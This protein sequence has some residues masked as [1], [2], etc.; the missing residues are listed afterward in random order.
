V[1]SARRV[2][3][4]LSRHRKSRQRFA[5]A[6][7]RASARVGGMCWAQTWAPFS[8]AKRSSRFAMS[9]SGLR[10]ALSD[11]S[12][13][14][15]D[16]SGG[17]RPPT[18]VMELALQPPEPHREPLRRS[19]SVARSQSTVRAPVRR[20]FSDCS[21]VLPL[22][23]IRA[24]ADCRGGPISHSQ[25]HGRWT[26]LWGTKLGPLCGAV[27]DATGRR[28]FSVHEP[29][30]HRCSGRRPHESVS[31]WREARSASVVGCRRVSRLRIDSAAGR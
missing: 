6:A 22:G 4:W 24:S 26:P 11:A 19:A 2:Q 23:T 12:R 3:R 15:H 17:D 20:L 21:A 1:R 29:R 7:L 25:R 27:T 30:V 8:A 16:R 13:R 9:I 10:E 14:K 31:R 5:T 28:S 18:I